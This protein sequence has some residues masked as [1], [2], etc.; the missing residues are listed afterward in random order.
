MV[1]VSAHQEARSLSVRYRPCCRLGHHS[2]AKLRTVALATDDEALA[3]MGATFAAHEALRSRWQAAEAPPVGSELE[4]ADRIWPHLPYTEHARQTLTAAW[5]HFDV[6]RLT[7]EARRTFPTGLNGVLRGA[8][9]ASAMA[10]WLLCPDSHEERVERGLALTDEWYVRRIRYQTDVLQLVEGAERLAGEAQVARLR[11]DHAEAMQLRRTN[12]Q[13]QATAI[14]DWSAGVRYGCGGVAH[15]Q[16][17]LEWQRLGGDAHAL[18]WQLLLQ[19]VEWRGDAAQAGLVE[20]HVTAAFSNVAEPYL[21]A[22]HMFTAALG[23]FDELGAA[24]PP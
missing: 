18:G 22:W 9:V 10:M 19:N 8:L 21:C 1:I 20:A 2:I 6:V 15:K 4:R 16:A 23:R 3:A 5:D 11:Q 14:I 17:L 13:V 7:I 12:L 24:P